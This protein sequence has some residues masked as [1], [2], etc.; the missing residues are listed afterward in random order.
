MGLTTPVS[1]T[2]AHLAKGSSLC[3]VMYGHLRNKLEFIKPLQKIFF[4]KQKLFG[5]CQYFVICRKIP[6]KCGPVMLACE[7]AL[8][9]P[10]L[11]PK[12]ELIAFELKALHG[13]KTL[14]R[15]TLSYNKMITLLVP[16]PLYNFP[17]TTSPLIT[18]VRDLHFSFNL[19]PIHMMIFSLK[20]SQM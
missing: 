11:S 9:R 7:V 18:E 3:Y 20:I 10:I 16:T 1:M 6:T 14:I 8:Q 4:K 19:S 12:K 5:G 2:D 15:L 17:A 13:Y